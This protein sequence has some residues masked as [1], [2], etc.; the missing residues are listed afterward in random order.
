[1]K[2]V[3]YL[4]VLNSQFNVN[5]ADK[6]VEFST[7]YQI[8][9]NKSFLGLKKQYGPRLIKFLKKKKVDNTTKAGVFTITKKARCSGEDVFDENK[10]KTIARVKVEIATCEISSALLGYL[11]ELMKKDQELLYKQVGRADIQKSDET[12]YFYTITSDI[13]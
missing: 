9:F 6:T 10:G 1:M 3:V 4:K 11:H 8:G 5:E 13:Q 12:H 2:D 7:T